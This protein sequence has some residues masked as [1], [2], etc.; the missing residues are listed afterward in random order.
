MSTT[1]PATALPQRTC[2]GCATTDNHP[3]CIE[4]RGDDSEITWHMD[5]HDIAYGPL[6]CHA[7]LYR[8]GAGLQGDALRSHIVSGG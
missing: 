7:V 2:I 5:C 1:E 4:D 8:G 3:R 6:P